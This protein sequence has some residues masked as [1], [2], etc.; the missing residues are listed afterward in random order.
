MEEKHQEEKFQREEHQREEHQREEH[1]VEEFHQEKQKVEKF[2]QEKHQVEMSQQE[3]HQEDGINTVETLKS[4]EITSLEARK[5]WFGRGIYG[6]KDVPIR[7]LD[8][9]IAVFV[10]A[11]IGM[12]VFFTINGGYHVAFDT[13]GG[14]GVTSQK[15]RYGELVAEP[16]VP[17][18]PGYQFEYWYQEEEPDTMWN[19]STRKVGGDVT[20]CAQWVPAKILVKFDLDGG[21]TSDGNMSI[22]PKEVV[23]NEIYGELPTPVK[24]G[25]TFAGWE[26][27]GSMISA[28]SVVWMTGEH[29]LKA[30]WR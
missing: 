18:K 20:L 30:I 1:P 6:S 29:V 7:L 5:K 13:F 4:E 11:I 26:Y 16:E 23:F 24:E 9:L 14:S 12:I 28:D 22:A 27:S 17:M 3:K 2:H 8:G 25:A 15:L 21:V 10:I 19:F